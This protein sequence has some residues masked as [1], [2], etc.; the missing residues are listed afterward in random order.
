MFNSGGARLCG[1]VCVPKNPKGAGLVVVVGGPQYRVGSHRQ[2]VLLAR[3]AAE[4]GYASLRFDLRGM[5]D[6]D[7]DF[8]GFEAVDGDIEAAIA[9]LKRECDA[10]RSI[11]LWGLCD[12]ASAALLYM[13]SRHDACIGGLCL[14]NPWVRSAASLARTE[15]RHYYRQ[16]LLT[17]A[18]WRKLFG[19]GVAVRTALAEWLGKLRLSRG[20]NA[21]Q[22]GS[23]QER[24]A[25]G[26]RGF[27][28][29][30]RLVLSERDYTAK[31]FVEFAQ[32][33]PAWHGLVG[34]GGVLGVTIEGA[35]HTFSSAAWRARVEEIT[36]DWLAGL[37]EPA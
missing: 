27:R 22:A 18:F 9:V 4:A 36:L 21:L 30:V 29:S 20:A 23:F 10:V 6:S 1:V 2:F 13:Q 15:V 28:G 5:G 32:A 26:L 12:G 3:H 34:T 7:G 11:G 24:M 16:R 8:P 17:V 33:D 25:A 19:G 31:E 35:D 37:G 14:L